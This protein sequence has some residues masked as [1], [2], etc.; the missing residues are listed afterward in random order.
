MVF[1]IQL[2]QKLNEKSLYQLGNFRPQEFLFHRFAVSSL[3][4]DAWINDP[5]SESEDETVPD[6]N[7]SF[8]YNNNNRNNDQGTFYGESYYHASNLDT[9]GASGSD[10]QQS[11]KYVEPTAEELE[12]QRELR[13]Q[14]EKM[15]P[16]Y[17]DKTSKAKPTEKVRLKSHRIVPSKVFFF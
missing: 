17:L 15:N 13:K 7:T 12:N 14:S 9:H 6:K 11:K 2:R 4:L 10:Y 8:Q 5:P 16:Y 3:D 1:S